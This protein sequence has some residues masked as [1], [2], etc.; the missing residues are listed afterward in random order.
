MDSN[1]ETGMEQPQAEVSVTPETA[2]PVKTNKPSLLE[3]LQNMFTGN[4]SVIP[5]SPSE[6][7]LYNKPAFERKAEDPEKWE[8]M[9]R[10]A[11]MPQP[12]PKEPTEKPA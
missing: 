7:P 6:P 1:V 2:T 11:A 10:N 3:K 9:K 4:S 12:T 8:E 5:A